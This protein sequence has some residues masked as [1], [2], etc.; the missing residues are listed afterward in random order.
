MK[1]TLVHP[2]AKMA[3]RKKR[4]RRIV[5]VLLFLLVLGPLALLALYGSWLGSGGMN[6]ELERELASRLRCNA[7][8]LGAHPTGLKTAVASHVELL[9]RAG[10][11][12]LAIALEDLE[13]EANEFGWHV[14]AARGAVKIAGPDPAA[15]LAAVNQR[16][17]QPSG[18]GTPAGPGAETP[19]DATQAS[20][21]ASLVVERL[22]ADLDLGP[23]RFTGEVAAVALSDTKVFRVTVCPPPTSAAA[24]W[25]THYLLL[26][27]KWTVAVLLNPASDRGVFGGLKVDAKDVPAA[28]IRQLLGEPEEEASRTAGT[29][30][31]S[32]RWHWP[33]GEADKAT[34]AVRG[35]DLELAD[36]TRDVPGGPITGKVPVDADYTKTGAGPGQFQCTVKSDGGGLVSA[37]T[38]RWLEETLPSAHGYGGLLTDSIGYERLAVNFRTTAEGLGC[39]AEGD[40]ST[41]LLVTELSGEEVPILWATA[42]PFQGRGVLEKLLPALLP[43]R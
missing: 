42:E 14:R 29:F 37:E 38:L 6:A 19:Q 7:H 16:L 26:A 43:S 20:P 4:V 8:V 40:D 41:P 36:W 32:V 35:R 39:L 10:P 31:V 5:F 12:H 2:R 18:H 34:V 17:V 1:Q 13:A 22:D 21:L 3:L 23:A 9:W 27:P 11:G 15:T 28:E 25:T 24:R 30:D 33:E